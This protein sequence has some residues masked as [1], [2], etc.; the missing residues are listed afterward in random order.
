M[1]AARKTKGSLLRDASFVAYLVRRPRGPCFKSRDIHSGA[2]AF[3]AYDVEALVGWDAVKTAPKPFLALG[4][5][6]VP[7][8]QD[9]SEAPIVEALPPPRRQGQVDRW[10][11]LRDNKAV[12]GWVNLY[13]FVDAFKLTATTE[14]KYAVKNSLKRL[15]G[16]G[17]TVK[18]ADPCGVGRPAKHARVC[19]LQNVYKELKL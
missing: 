7:G 2:H 10:E 9:V 12:N 3:I 19:D 5:Q 13:H 18:D 6:L 4:N 1:K 8:C 11:L 14:P 17:C 15:R 16:A